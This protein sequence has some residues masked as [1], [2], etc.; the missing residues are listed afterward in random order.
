MYRNGA[1]GDSGPHDMNAAPWATEDKM[2]QWNEPGLNSWNSAQKPKTP[3]T[4]SGG[5]N[6]G[7]VDPSSWGHVSKMVSFYQIFLH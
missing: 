4:P 1:W 2:P 5:W 6:E 3:I 7:E